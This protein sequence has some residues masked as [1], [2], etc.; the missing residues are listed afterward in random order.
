[1]MV[2]TTLRLPGPLMDILRERSR[3]EGRSVND[4]AVRALAAGLGN[5]QI[6]EGW[7]TLGA[8]VEAPPTARF[9][10]SALRR[11]RRRL[12]GASS[13]LESDLEWV[14]GDR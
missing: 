8:L 3:R 13:G 12:G 14:R 2:K 6:D 1:M 11:Q 4:T 5:D 9:D 7:R 10:P